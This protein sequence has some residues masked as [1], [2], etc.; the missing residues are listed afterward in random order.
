[1]ASGELEMCHVARYAGASNTLD[2]HRQ[3]NP[4][5]PTVTRVSGSQVD[6]IKVTIETHLI[7]RL[8][9]YCVF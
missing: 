3:T 8:T 2:T 1:M 7:Q 5:Q 4:E 9:V 6:G